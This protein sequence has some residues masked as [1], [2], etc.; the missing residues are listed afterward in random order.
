MNSVSVF[1]LGAIGSN[2]LIQ[3]AKLH[4]EMKFYGIDF[5]KV[6]TRNIKN[7]AYFL[8]HVGKYKATAMAIVLARYLTKIQY[9]PISSEIESTMD[10]Y[11][12][13]EKNTLA[14]DCFDNTKSRKF[15]EEVKDREILHIGFSPSYTAE[16]IW[17]ENYD[18][19]NDVPADMDICS[20][21]RAIPFIGLVVNFAS[22]VIADYLEFGNK[23]NFI[24][25]NKYQ[26][27]AI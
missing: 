9:V 21:D 25:T 12:Y 27:K 11:R 15:F 3:L 10:V 6:E 23:K 20:L 2:L 7:Q 13:T 4:P 26:I 8:E 24:I 1:G 17:H 18:V 22:M 16:I 19:P 5:D 14:I